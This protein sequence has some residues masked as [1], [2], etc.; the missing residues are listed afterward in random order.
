[1][2]RGPV[3]PIGCR[4]IA[5]ETASLTAIRARSAASY[6]STSIATNGDPYPFPS[7]W[8]GCSSSSRCSGAG[9]SS[10]SAP[11]F[12]PVGFG[13]VMGCPLGPQQLPDGQTVSQCVEGHVE[14]V[15]PMLGPDEPVDRPATARSSPGCHVG[16]VPTPCRSRA[17]RRPLSC[18]DGR[19]GDERGGETD[20]GSRR[21]PSRDLT[22]NAIIEAGST[23]GQPSLGNASGGPH[24]RRRFPFRR[25]VH[26]R[27]PLSG[28]GR[29]QTTPR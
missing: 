20:R 26:R 14:V 24:G 19:R 22:S 25:A 23:A 8:Q 7:R 17:P 10:W 28:R 2:R 12:N 3:T 9:Q 4:C 29:F 21:V 16:V 27:R 15:E 1:M 6:A 18:G 11:I 5:R 13:V